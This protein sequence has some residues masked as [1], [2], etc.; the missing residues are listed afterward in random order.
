MINGR[1][2]MELVDTHAHLDEGAFG[3]DR[4]EVVAQA[5]AAGVTRI[6]T[7]GTTAA[8]SEAAV[9]VA[10]EFPGVFAAVGIQPNYAAEAQP[11]GD[12]PP[13][14]T[15]AAPVAEGDPASAS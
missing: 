14:D 13:A 2:V 11:E 10:G 5:A 3:F 15:A 1:T 6:I 8:S 7:I 12:A 9:A 4:A